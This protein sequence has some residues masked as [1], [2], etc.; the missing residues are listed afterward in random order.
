[1]G[2]FPGAQRG[3]PCRVIGQPALKFIV[4]GGAVVLLADMGQLVHDN[5]FAQ[6]G[7]Q[8]H[9]P[10]GIADAVSPGTAAPAVRGGRNAYGGGRNAHAGRPLR[11]QRGQRLPRGLPQQFR[12]SRR[13]HPHCRGT[14]LLG[15][16]VAGDP[17]GFFGEKVFN[18]ALGR[19]QRC[20]HR[21]RS[22]CIHGDLD[23][24][25]LGAD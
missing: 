25:A 5:I 6:Q 3:L 4:K 7:R 18:Q 10:Q 1:M 21:D 11:G 12:F 17:V 8:Q 9:D 15:R 2:L 14:G 16:D 19:T 22:G 13:E 23:R 24:F 20:A